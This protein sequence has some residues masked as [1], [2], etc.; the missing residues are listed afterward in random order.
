MPKGVIPI[1]S[2]HTLH[3]CYSNCFLWWSQMRNETKKKS[4]KR[5][6]INKADGGR[7]GAS[8]IL[9][10]H[11]SNLSGSTYHITRTFFLASGQQRDSGRL[12]QTARRKQRASEK[13]LKQA[14]LSTDRNC[15]QQS[16]FSCSALRQGSRKKEGDVPRGGGHANSDDAA[17]HHSSR[18]GGR[19][20]LCR[21]VGLRGLCSASLPCRLTASLSQVSRQ[22]TQGALP[23]Q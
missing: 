13:N 9:Y 5:S 10:R 21:A 4:L 20:L 15:T 16:V 12:V 11:V 22:Q 19:F 2:P 3:R 7:W 23:T 8:K 14:L 17:E 1:I 6:H 18:L